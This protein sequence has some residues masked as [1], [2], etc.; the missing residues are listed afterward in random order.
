M[1]KAYCD[2]VSTTN[3]SI[4]DGIAKRRPINEFEETSYFAKDDYIGHFRYTE[5]NNCSNPEIKCTGHFIDFPCQWTSYFERQAYWNNIS[6]ENDIIYDLVGDFTKT[7]QV[8]E[9]SKATKSHISESLYS[10]ICHL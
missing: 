5:K 8:F 6:L 1:W 9:A 2:E 4:D 10:N 3:C 7:R